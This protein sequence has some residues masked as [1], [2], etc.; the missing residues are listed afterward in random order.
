M[1][2]YPAV[3]FPAALRA[4]L[5]PEDLAIIHGLAP[6]C[7]V[8]RRSKQRTYSDLA[9]DSNRMDSLTRLAGVCPAVRLTLLELGELA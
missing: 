7:H 2:T 1:R 3:E 6:R 9:M 4:A 5:T 8:L